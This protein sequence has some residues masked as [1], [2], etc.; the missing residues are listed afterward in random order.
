MDNSLEAPQKKIKT[1][2][3]YDLAK[4]L[5]DIYPKEMKLVY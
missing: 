4:P 2:L 1:E 3:S 5:L